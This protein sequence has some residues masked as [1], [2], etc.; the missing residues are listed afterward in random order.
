MS[1]QEELLAWFDAN[2]RDLPWRATAD[3]YAI[4][5]SEIMLQQTQVATV[6]P[7]YERW[8]ERFPT[9][10]SLALADEQEVL[11]HWQGLGYYRRC[12]ML[13][14]AAQALVSTGAPQT[15]EDWMKVRGVGRYT[16]GAISSI[17]HGEPVPLVDGN[18][19]RVFARVT[20]E[21]STRPQLTE[22]AWDWAAAQM[23]TKRPGDW[24]QALMELG[25]TICRFDNPKC[26]VCPVARECLAHARG[27]VEEIPRAKPAAVVKHLRHVV[28]VPIH[29]GK[30]GLRQ[31][32]LQQWWA[33]MWEF[34][35]A[36]IPGDAQLEASLG[37]GWVQDLGTIKHTVTNHRITIRASL[38]HCD[39]PGNEVQWFTAGELE[40]LPLPAPQR[41][42]LRLAQALVA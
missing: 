3:P 15:F 8:M 20:A 5:V 24:N 17:A 31:I 13:H 11:S 41:K 29:S 21:T 18:V 37:P 30:Y 16:A 10:A 39:E 23:Y 27:L 14:A 9:I 33:G 28:Y 22:L 12:K 6:L 1:L 38:K 34:P 32:G 42:I 35:R 40:A 7:Y 36:D 26:E 25:A 19:E 2:K 4:W